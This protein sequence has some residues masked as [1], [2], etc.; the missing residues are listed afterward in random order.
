MSQDHR[1]D[2]KAYMFVFGALM[3]GTVVTVLASHLDL[4]RPLALALGLAIATVKA[5][6]V[7]AFFMH[8]KGERPIIYGMLGVTV[9]FTAILFWGPLTDS[10]LTAEHRV[11]QEFPSEE[12]HEPAHETP[13]AAP[14]PAN[15]DHSEHEHSQK[16][17]H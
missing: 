10:N 3:V 8:L 13:A 2:V 11:A 7:A 14:A 9:F 1:P 12:A 4:P 16:K 6:F 17:K 5:A 15:E